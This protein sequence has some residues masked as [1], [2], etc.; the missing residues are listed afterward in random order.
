MGDEAPELNAGLPP[1]LDVHVAVYAVI[2]APPSSGGAVNETT[3]RPSPGTTAGWLGAS[4]TLAATMADGNELTLANPPLFVAVSWTRSRCPT[5]ALRGT[6]VALVAPLM[7]EHDP[8]LA[9]HRRH[10][11]AMERGNDPTQVGDQSESGTP[12]TGSHPMIGNPVGTGAT[13][14]TT[15]VASDCASPVPSSFVAVTATR[16]LWSRSAPVSV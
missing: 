11:Y 7:S 2:V 16:I 6:Y 14:P 5:S 4:G 12:R 10:W 1:L 13:R 8:P 9:S 3:I 15:S